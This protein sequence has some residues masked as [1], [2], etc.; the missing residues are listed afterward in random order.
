MQRGIKILIVYLLYAQISMLPVIYYSLLLP[1]KNNWGGNINPLILNRVFEVYQKTLLY[2]CFLLPWGYSH[3]SY[4]SV[5]GINRD[6]R[7]P[8]MDLKLNSCYTNLLATWTTHS[9]YSCGNGVLRDWWEIHL[10]NDGE[11]L[12][13]ADLKVQKLDINMGLILYDTEFVYFFWG[14][15]MR[16]F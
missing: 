1:I 6:I 8:K 2:N 12:S 10:T 16:L 11:K 9:T 15:S 14:G 5:Y 13:V 4:I 7:L 3:T